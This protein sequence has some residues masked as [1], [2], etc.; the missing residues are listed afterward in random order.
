MCR[1]S[2][3]SVPP[4]LG[5]S[6][7]RTPAASTVG[8]RGPRWVQPHRGHKARVSELYYPCSGKLIAKGKEMNFRKSMLLIFILL[9]PFFSTSQ[10]SAST[11]ATG[12][13]CS[14]GDTGPGGGVVFFVKS[15]YADTSISTQNGTRTTS[16]T[17]SELSALPF[18]YLEA[19]PIGWDASSAT[20]PEWK[21]NGT[22]SSAG[23]SAITDD[24]IGT[25]RNN[26]ELM[27][28]LNPTDSAANNIAYKLAE[29]SIG[30]LNDWWL[31]SNQELI[32]MFTN[33]YK[34]SPT[35][36]GEWRNQSNLAYRTSTAAM[37]FVFQWS[38]PYEGNNFK[39]DS[40]AWP[41]PV[42]PIRGFS[43]TN[44]NSSSDSAAQAAAEAADAA[45]RE[46]E[47]KAARAEIL[48][49]FKSSEKVTIETFNQAEIAGITKENFEAVSAEILALPEGSRSDITQVLKVAY[50]YEVVGIIASE[51]VK[52]IYSNR[53][54]EIGLI[55]EESKHKEAL[56]AAMK[57]LPVSERSSYAALKEAIG[58]EMAEIQGRK[59]RYTAILALIASRRNG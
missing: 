46:V 37:F 34:A 4:H 6:K 8:L 29:S 59:D 50:K 42:K 19:A 48:S 51:R 58:N 35:R 52:S 54:I 53:L 20:D 27:R 15:S 12:G 32:L 49:K 22:G 55:H 26:T 31:P 56:T 24:K 9:M 17:S 40:S 38:A 57:K 5:S 23:Y 13:V 33:L 41:Y 47:K 10:A 39:F 1:Y 18:E 21:Y 36:L 7:A 28:T 3:P 43:A 44:S 2:V 14:I 25:G 30:G 11:C 45:K 16:L